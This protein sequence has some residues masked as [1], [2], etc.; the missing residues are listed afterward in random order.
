M[1]TKKIITVAILASFGGQLVMPFAA[2]AASVDGTTTRAQQNFCSR[3]PGLATQTQDATA[4]R[5]AHL[6]EQKAKQF[7]RIADNRERKDD[8]LLHNR[9]EWD[10]NRT[11][12]YD[13]LLARATTTAQKEAIA[14]FQSTVEKLVK[15]RRDA[16]DK[17]HTTFRTGV[18]TITTSR[19][20]SVERAITTF[21][22]TSDAALSQA[23]TDCDVGNN[24]R[25]IREA[26]RTSTEAARKKMQ[27]DRRA[28]EKT[29]ASIEPL[30]EARRAAVEKALATFKAGIEQARTELKAAFK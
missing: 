11:E 18:D 7:N 20:T 5:I 2:F 26:Y 15:E 25:V 19:K 8:R 29:R 6:E 1:N 27:D 10:S 30:I 28:I 16:M 3:L 24:P 22:N 23:K 13:K 4:Q 9:S 14:K 17:A 12:H 21:K